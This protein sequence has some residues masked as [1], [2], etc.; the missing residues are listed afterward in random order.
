MRFE[1]MNL[2]AH[3]RLR[4]AQI[5]GGERDA[6]PAADGDEAAYQIERRKANERR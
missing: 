2:P 5:L 3:G 4:D 6:H 1:R